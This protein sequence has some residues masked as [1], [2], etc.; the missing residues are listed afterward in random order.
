MTAHEIELIKRS[1]SRIVPVANAAVYLFFSKL[2]EL[3]PELKELSD[4]MPQS[5]E[6]RYF[7]ILLYLINRIEKSDIPETLL[8]HFGSQCR[9]LGYSD[10]QLTSFS[11]AFYWTLEQTLRSAFTE[12]VQVSWRSFIR[13]ILVPIQQGYNHPELLVHFSNYSSTDTIKRNNRFCIH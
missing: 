13:E 5:E 6:Q 11:N 10:L 4:A 1:V 9:N 3:H 2:Y 8:T 12:E 7:G